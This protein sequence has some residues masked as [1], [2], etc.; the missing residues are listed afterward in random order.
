MT[1]Q[2]FEQIIFLYFVLRQTR[3]FVAEIFHHHD[4]R[5]PT[6]NLE[7]NILTQDYLKLESVILENSFDHT[8]TVTNTTGHTIIK[9]STS[10]SI[11]EVF[12]AE[13]RYSLYLLIFPQTWHL[14]YTKCLFLVQVQF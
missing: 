11:P 13:L 2:P 8:Y 10:I 14:D 12:C 4:S 7:L 1:F 9:V 5:A 3:S 6:E